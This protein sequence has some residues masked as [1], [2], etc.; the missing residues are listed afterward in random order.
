MISGRFNQTIIPTLEK[1][2][3]IRRL[4]GRSFESESEIKYIYVI[5]EI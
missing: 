4:E 5:F 1:M 3:G 2:Y